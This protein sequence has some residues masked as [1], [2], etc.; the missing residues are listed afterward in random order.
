[1]LYNI[2]SVSVLHHTKCLQYTSLLF[3]V[4]PYQLTVMQFSCKF[5]LL[6]FN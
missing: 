4:L 2:I 1:M 3:L 5:Y 6:I